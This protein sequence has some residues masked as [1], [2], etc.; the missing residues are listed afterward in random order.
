MAY[1][2]TRKNDFHARGILT[3]TGMLI[4]VFGFEILPN[5]IFLGWQIFRYFS[6]F[7]KISDIFLG[8]DKFP[9]IFFGLPIFVSHT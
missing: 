9:A 4:L 7:R 1:L 3:V 2:H 5:P 6:G 8:V